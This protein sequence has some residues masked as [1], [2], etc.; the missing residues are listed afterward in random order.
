M[1]R[2]TIVVAVVCAASMVRA[3]ETPF[4]LELDV[5]AGIG[6][7]V[8]RQTRQD[9][10]FLSEGWLNVRP[11][12]EWSHVRVRLPIDAQYWRATGTELQ[13][14]DGQARV[15]L[16][17]SPHRRFKLYLEGGVRGVL[18]QDW[19]DQYQ[20]SSNTLLPTNRYSHWRQR[21]ETEMAI[22][23]KRHHHLWIRYRYEIVEYHQD[24]L[25]D[26]VNRPT[27][28]LPRTNS[29]HTGRLAWHT[30]VGDH[31]LA[32]ELDG[33]YKQYTYAFS[34]DE[35]TGRTHAGPRGAPPNPLERLVGVDPSIELRLDFVDDLFRLTL[36]YRHA[37]Q[38]D[39]FQGYR[40][41]HGPKPEIRLRWK[42]RQSEF[43]VAANVAHYVYFDGGYQE[44][45]NHPPLDYGSRRRDTRAS[46]KAEAS[47]GVGE[48]TTLFARYRLSFRRTNFPDYQPGIFPATRSYAV[49][50]D[51]LNHYLLMGVEFN[52]DW[53]P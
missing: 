13:Q 32:I 41:L 51:Y 7:L 27:H 36:G 49:D 4:S 37:I 34:R 29:N 44:A 1:L 40:S 28:L 24:P 11:Q 53:H 52:F 14:L 20:P 18:R 33:E 50:W 30:I 45:S 21:Y 10:G 39:L 12:L 42:F 47:T 46:L 31:R 6:A 43:E 16:R 35:G 9:A 17:W 3:D 23:P 25:F 22:V 5:G 2:A 48:F 8:G 15:Q 19:P 38:I 26:G